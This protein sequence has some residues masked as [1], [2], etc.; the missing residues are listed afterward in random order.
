[1]SRMNSDQIAAE[2]L[3]LGATLY[4]SPMYAHTY[5]LPITGERVCVKRGQ[6]GKPMAR[7][8]LVIHPRH[9]ELPHWHSLQA[10]APAP[11]LAYHNADL[12]GFPL[13]KSGA[14]KVGIAFDIA[15]PQVLARFVQAMTDA[16]SDTDGPMQRLQRAGAQALLQDDPLFVQ[17]PET[18]RQQLVEARI[19]QGRF[20]QELLDW[21]QGQCAVTGVGLPE[22]L[23]AS[24]IKPWAQAD[25]S[26]RLD[27]YNGL[28][29]SA[30]LDRLF[31]R[32]LI[33]FADDGR[34]L[35]ASHVSDSDL[36]R[37]GIADD[38]RLRRLAPQHL[39]Y[40]A[41]HRRAFGFD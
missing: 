10:L 26:E 41:Y 28:L 8:P 40:L 33:G 37:L 31:D 30:N 29:L 35:R 15:S 11:N 1:M 39:P 27:A 3:R 17:A 9:R 34:L 16:S 22:V 6:A 5:Q 25:N 13:G 32:G 7:Q 20:R 18:V 24:H 19:G 4:R 21:W 38:A 36:A 12:H 2:L 14:S 23:V